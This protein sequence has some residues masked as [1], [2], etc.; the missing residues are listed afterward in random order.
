MAQPAECP[1]LVLVTNSRFASLSPTSGSVLSAGSL[2]Q[3]LSAPPPQARSVSLK[4]KHL[5]VSILYTCMYLYVRMC[6]N[7][8]LSIQL[9]IS[10]QVMISRFTSSSPASGSVLTARSLLGILPLP[11]FAPPWLMCALQINN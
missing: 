1:T 10:A 9:L 8:Q 5:H 2:L 7:S 3:F 6:I 4:N 11:L